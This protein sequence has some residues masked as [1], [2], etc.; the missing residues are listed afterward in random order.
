[1]FFMHWPRQFY[2]CGLPNHGPIA[3]AQSI[4]SQPSMSSG[5]PLALY[6]A[7][8]GYIEAA[9][10]MMQPGPDQDD[11]KSRL[12]ADQAKHIVACLPKY[13]MPYE[14]ATAIL[15]AM[16]SLGCPFGDEQVR[17]ISQVAKS[18]QRKTATSTPQPRLANT[19]Q[20][21][22]HLQNYVPDEL[23]GVLASPTID[24]KKKMHG[25]AGLMMRIG[26]RNP[27]ETTKVRAVAIMHLASGLS[28]SPEEAYQHV[29][30]FGEIVHIKRQSI[31]GSQ[32]MAAFPEDPQEPRAGGGHN[33]MHRRAGGE[34]EM[35]RE[36]RARI[37]YHI[38]G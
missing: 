10:A 12:V 28:P 8:V 19:P 11:E 14:Q 7:V 5:T 15:Q 22:P 16:K 20:S 6:K 33:T 36:V 1:M 17:A 23:W 9:A 31:A 34:V 21:H 13:D 38:A 30:D 4:Q 24:M 25:M 32:S 18:C 26:C 35:R 37:P 27:N 29:R 3:T 2:L